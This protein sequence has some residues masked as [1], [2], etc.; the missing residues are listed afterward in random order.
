MNKNSFKVIPVN[1]SALVEPIT[2]AEYLKLLGEENPEELDK[3]GTLFIPRTAVERNRTP[4]LYQKARVIALSEEK[5]EFDLRIGDIVVFNIEIKLK[6]DEK[7]EV[8]LSAVRYADIFCIIRE[9]E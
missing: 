5:P 1:K 2:E 3:V 9:E 7:S 4:V 6:Y 8:S